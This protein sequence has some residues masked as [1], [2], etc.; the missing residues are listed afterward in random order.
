MPRLLHLV[1][2]LCLLR[3]RDRT[4]RLHHL[5]RLR[6][7]RHLLR[8]HRLPC[9]FIWPRNGC[10]SSNGNCWPAIKPTV[11]RAELATGTLSCARARMHAQKAA[12][13]T[14]V[15]QLDIAHRFMVESIIAD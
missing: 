1:R 7:V 2:T 14:L 4:L 12:W 15:P 11:R 5:L 8:I 10:H 3:L 9:V 13:F 6:H